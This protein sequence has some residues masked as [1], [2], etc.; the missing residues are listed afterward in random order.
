MR[1]GILDQEEAEVGQNC[2][3]APLEEREDLP[4]AY[5]EVVGTGADLQFLQ[6]G[7]ETFI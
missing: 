4:P 3:A 1:G 5:A 7:V 2:E 6:V